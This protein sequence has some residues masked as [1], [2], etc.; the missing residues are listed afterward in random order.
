MVSRSHTR[1]SQ[2]SRRFGATAAFS[3]KAAPT[4][5]SVTGANIALFWNAPRKCSKAASPLVPNSPSPLS[6][7]SARPAGMPNRRGGTW[8]GVSRTHSAAVP[9]NPA[10]RIAIG[11]PTGAP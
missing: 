6:A 5:G 7:A 11:A 1:A 4:G 9:S 2:R 10:S 8:P 3:S